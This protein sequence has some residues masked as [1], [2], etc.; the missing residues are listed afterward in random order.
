MIMQE[1]YTFCD[2][3][4]LQE[5]SSVSGDVEGCCKPNQTV[6]VDI[7]IEAHVREQVALRHE[8]G[9]EDR[10]RPKHACAEEGQN[11]GMACATHSLQLAVQQLFRASVRAAR[12]AIHTF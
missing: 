5:D 3:D 9:H 8:R 2:L 7:C 10:L 4:N 11:A 1:L 12:A 6:A